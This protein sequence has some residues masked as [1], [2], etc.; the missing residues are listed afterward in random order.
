MIQFFSLCRYQLNVPITTIMQELS[1]LYG[2]RAPGIIKLHSWIINKK[3]THLVEQI[4]LTNEMS[5]P[6][7][8]VNHVNYISQQPQLISTISN[9]KI[10]LKIL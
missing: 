7:T 1:K 6:A 4:D 8:N 10:E 2:S 3:K 5:E 9:R